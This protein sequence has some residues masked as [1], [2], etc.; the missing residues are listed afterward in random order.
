MAPQKQDASPCPAGEWG[1][2][3]P[4]IPPARGLG[5]PK[6]PRGH[7]E[8]LS[9]LLAVLGRAEAARYAQTPP[10]AQRLDVGTA[11]HIWGV[12]CPPGRRKPAGVVFF[13]QEQKDF[14]GL[15]PWISHHE[16]MCGS[17]VS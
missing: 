16:R 13:S 17:E 5:L 8:V 4:L 7:G 9:A 6:D 14:S 1:L 2:K 11:R 3:K 15:R 12:S 10:V